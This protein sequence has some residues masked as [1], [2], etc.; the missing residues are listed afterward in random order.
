MNKELL[1]Y[2][3]QTIKLHK[4][5]RLTY[6]MLKNLT[7]NALSDVSNQQFEDHFF[8][9]KEM[10]YISYHNTLK[11]NE[12]YIYNLGLTFYGQTTLAHNELGRQDQ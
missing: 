5:R 3:L 12:H 8:Y 11:D 4:D 2:I 9:L 7:A 1:V 6:D 10:G